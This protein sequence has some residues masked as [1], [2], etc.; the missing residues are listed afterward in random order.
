MKVNDRLIVWR[1]EAKRGEE[2]L[3]DV[4]R[5]FEWNRVKIFVTGWKK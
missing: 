2:R 5:W 4:R 3:A 1:E